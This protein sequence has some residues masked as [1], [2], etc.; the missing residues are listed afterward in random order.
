MPKGDSYICLVYDLTDSGQNEALWDTKLWMPSVEN[1]L[2]PATHSPWFDNVETFEMFH[3]YKLSEKSQPY[4]GWMFP[5]P[6]KVRH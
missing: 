2:Y 4:A 1:V 5:G 3:N 6:K